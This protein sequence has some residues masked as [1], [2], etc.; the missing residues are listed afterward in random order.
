MLIPII[1]FSAGGAGGVSA[2][3]VSGGTSGEGSDYTT[4]S[5]T[6]SLPTGQVAPAGGL[7]VE[8]ESRRDS[9][10]VLIEE[11]KSSASYTIV[12]DDRLTFIPFSSGIDQVQYKE[13]T[14]RNAL[15]SP[16]YTLEACYSVYGKI[17]IKSVLEDDYSLRI[18]AHQGSSTRPLNDTNYAVIKAGSAEIDYLI[19]LDDVSAGDD[20]YVTIK[21]SSSNEEKYIPFEDI[22]SDRITLSGYV[23]EC[24]FSEVSIEKAAEVIKGTVSLP[25]FLK[26]D[27]NDI[28]IKAIGDNYTLSTNF[29]TV[30]GSDS[31]DFCLYGKTSDIKDHRGDYKLNV[32]IANYTDETLYYY[33][34]SLSLTDCSYISVTDTAFVTGLKIPEPN[35]SFSG[36]IIL[37]E[38]TAEDMTVILSLYNE[39]GHSIASRRIKIPEGSSTCSYRAEFL[40]K[41][42]TRC[43]LSYKVDRFS[44]YYDDDTKLFV[45]DDVY[46]TTLDEASLF[47][48]NRENTQT[49]ISLLPLYYSAFVEGTISL[50]SQYTPNEE[51]SLGVSLSLTNEALTFEDYVSFHNGETSNDYSFK[52]ADMYSDG[53]WILSYIIGSETEESSVPSI[54]HEVILDSDFFVPPQS[55]G[56]DGSAIWRDE[57]PEEVTAGIN[58]YVT[59]DGLSFNEG[60]AK[61]FTFDN[62]GFN[63]V[64]FTLYSTDNDYQRI[65]SGY[66][67]SVL[68]DISF[69]AKLIDCDTNEVVDTFSASSLE[70]ATK[71][72][73]ELNRSGRFTIK[74]SYE[75]K[76]YYYAEDNTLT[77]EKEDAL[78]IDALSYPYHYDNN[79]YYENIKEYKATT[80][81]RYLE[82]MLEG[83]SFD[84]FTVLLFG[85][86]GNIIA[87]SQESHS[88]GNLITDERKV[89]IG[90]EW[91]GE[92][93][94]FSQ[95]YSDR[96]NI[97][98]GSVKNIEDATAYT[99]PHVSARRCMVRLDVSDFVRGRANGLDGDVYI[100]ESYFNYEETGEGDIYIESLY[101]DISPEVFD[102]NNM[103]FV[104]LYGA[105]GK[106]L[107]LK[108]LTEF[109]EN[110][111]IDINKTIPL[112]G[113]A[114]VV[115][116]KPSLYP[117]FEPLNYIF[118]YSR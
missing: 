97:L 79:V 17:R 103:L 63:N 24:N 94:Y 80:N 46:A 45:A 74:F 96:E 37:K 53:T 82:F 10:T 16:D 83:Y 106:I 73:F 62:G 91:L 25:D 115:T 86:D 59:S 66:F 78:V 100:N 93:Y 36:N 15:S 68:K 22:T 19:T 109:P 40:A 84:G 29:D 113:C 52:I 6:I 27:S 28:T 118:T 33:N 69:T 90:Y 102:G 111:Y 8:V 99:L 105:D 12:S 43:A 58:F 89:Y 95:L 114:K 57:I 18:I 85:L 92:I 76:E 50:P 13:K 42:D 70:E 49:D 75:D 1:S 39:E 107:S 72:T 26:G 55:S 23:N 77:S 47:N 31:F 110:N 117:M 67:L 71:Y 64:D 116:L 44:D 2:G 88:E 4:I 56:S 38:D 112:D 61:K 3:G 7:K 54:P 32:E 35:T 34:G 11:G 87:S 108:P 98:Y 5:G 9:I 30:S 21:G 14:I 65:I 51:D 41:P 104:A 101:I 48:T 60:D 81:D 20:I